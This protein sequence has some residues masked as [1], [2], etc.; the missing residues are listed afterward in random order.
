MRR[1]PNKHGVLVNPSTSAALASTLPSAGSL[2]ATPMDK[3]VQLGLQGHSWARI[4]WAPEGPHG[5]PRKLH[6]WC[7]P[8]CQAGRYVDAFTLGCGCAEDCSPSRPGWVLSLERHEKRKMHQKNVAL[9]SAL[10]A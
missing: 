8:C 7:K 6:L 2:E 3:Y 5:R 1:G 10:L 9:H 4:A